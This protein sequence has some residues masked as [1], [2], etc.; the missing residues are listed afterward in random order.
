MTIVAVSKTTQR[1]LVLEN[2]FVYFKWEEITTNTS[3]WLG[4]PGVNRKY[5]VARM[6]VVE[7]GPDGDIGA[8]DLVFLTTRQFFWTYI[9][10]TELQTW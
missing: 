6:E 7:T 8:M 5:S 2:E 10:G 4:E 3:V 9:E 1:P